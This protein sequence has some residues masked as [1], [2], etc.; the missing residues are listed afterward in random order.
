M[1]RFNVELPDVVTVAGVKV[2][3]TPEGIP[4]TARETVPVKPFSGATVAE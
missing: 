3:V 4:E 2:P 1:A